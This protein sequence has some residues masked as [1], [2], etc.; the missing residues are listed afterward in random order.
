MLMS[1]CTAYGSAILITSPNQL[2][3][4]DVLNWSQLGG[5]QAAVASN[6]FAYT[7]SL[8]GSTFVDTVSVKM[9]SGAGRTLQAGTDWA[10]GNGFDNNDALLQTSSDGTRGSGPI[11]LGLNGSF[12]V[13][14]YID[15]GD[16][17]GQFTARIQAFTGIN[18]VLLDTTVKSDLSG[19]PLFIGALDTKADITRLVL[20]LYVNG[21]VD[22][23]IIIDKLLFQNQAGSPPPVIFNTPLAPPITLPAQVD[24]VP[25]PGAISL[26]LLG[27]LG[28]IYKGRNRFRKGC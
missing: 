3:S 17:V 26:M 24:P 12:G 15:T 11:T 8:T 9:A 20:S 14:A 2:Y 18:T 28:L 23:N 27:C 4:T 10:A 25:E 13:G 5:D 21:V 7:T 22:N 16:A 19:D 1:T 6:F